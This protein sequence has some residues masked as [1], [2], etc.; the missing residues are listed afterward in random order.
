MIIQ[1]SGNVWVCGHAVGMFYRLDRRDVRPFYCFMV[2][3]RYLSRW[4]V[5]FILSSAR[6]RFGRFGSNILVLTHLVAIHD[7][8]ERFVIGHLIFGV[9]SLG[10]SIDWGAMANRMNKLHAILRDSSAFR[11]TWTGDGY[12]FFTALSQRS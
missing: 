10:C 2:W 7:A 9:D 4:V 3:R 11:A 6:P 1:L 8:F 5:A 12:W